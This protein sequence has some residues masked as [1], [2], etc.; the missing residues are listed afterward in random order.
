MLKIFNR[1]ENTTNPY[2]YMYFMNI[3]VYNN[4]FAFQELTF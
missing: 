4:I 3:N 1:K 2:Q